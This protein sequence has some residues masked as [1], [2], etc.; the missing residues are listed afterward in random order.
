[1]SGRRQQALCKAHHPLAPTMKGG[2]LALLAGWNRLCG[3]SKLSLR[4]RSEVLR[5]IQTS[6]PERMLNTS[7]VLPSTCSR[8]ALPPPLHS[9]R[10]P[11][12]WSFILCC[13]LF[14]GAGWNRL[15]VSQ[16]SLQP[17]IPLLQPLQHEDY[18]PTCW[19][20]LFVK[21]YFILVMCVCVCMLVGIYM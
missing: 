2:N 12:A 15:Y 1:M 5:V 3:H 11:L 7:P 13:S 4:W 20:F 17:K 21:I 8:I 9:R 14:Q 6:V 19:E 10:S 16:A 18:R